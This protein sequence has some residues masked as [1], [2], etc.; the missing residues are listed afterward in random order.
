MKTN[1]LASILS[2]SV[3]AVLSC[4]PKQKK[5]MPEAKSSLVENLMDDKYLSVYDINTK[6][7]DIKVDTI[8]ARSLNDIRFGNWTD[9]D[10]VDNEYIRAIRYYLDDYNNGKIEN[11]ELD[12]YRDIVC[13]QFTIG[14]EKQFLLGGLYFKLI[15]LIDPDKVFNAWV[16]SEVDEEKGIVLNYSVRNLSFEEDGAGFTKEE[17]LRIAKEHPEVRIW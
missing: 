16:Y 14:D 17:I 12:D 11:P 9:E 3:I 10:W 7:N 8:P 6:D 4:M 5:E 2:I 13:G 15:F 1:V